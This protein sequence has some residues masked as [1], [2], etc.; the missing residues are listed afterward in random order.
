MHADQ[1]LQ[2]KDV[3]HYLVAGS[4]PISSFFVTLLDGFSIETLILIERASWWFHILGILAF[5][6]YVLI[7]KHLHIFFAF[8]ST[9][10]ANINKLGKIDNL[11][12]VTKEVK[13]MLDPNADPFA[14]SDSSENLPPSLFGARDA[15]D[16]NWVQLLK[17]L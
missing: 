15:T 5:L 7:S 3:S 8:P 17:R 13:L 1:I 9:Y 14:N 11:S 2:S 6:N 4:F 12:S 10:Y 16:L